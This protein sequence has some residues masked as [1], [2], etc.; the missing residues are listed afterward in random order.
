MTAS[1]TNHPTGSRRHALVAAAGLLSASLM[2][3]IAAAMS[4]LPEGKSI[5]KLKGTVLV[6][7]KRA[8]EDTMILAGDVIETKSDGEMVFAV[9]SSAFLIRRNSRVELSGSERI[10][11]ALRLVAGKLLS[12]YGKGKR[13][14][15]TPT[16]TIGIR[17]TGVYLE[18][19]EHRTYLCTCYGTVEMSPSTA[20]DV[21]E[22]V[23]TKHHEA[24][25]YINSFPGKAPEITPAPVINHTD[26]ELQLLEALVGRSPPFSSEGGDGGGY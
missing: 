2:P 23:T 17:G 10:V 5:Y 12:V 9:G 16:A 22:V 7:G 25:R 6:N 14:I 3:R 21:S 8:N 11:N 24:P 1:R 15:T 19:E 26:V 20:P 18:S 13:R 4:K